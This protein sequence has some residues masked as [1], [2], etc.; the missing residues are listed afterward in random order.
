MR[1]ILIL[2]LIL[3]VCA[4]L[5]AQES[6]GDDLGMDLFADA[7]EETDQSEENGQELD[8]FADPDDDSS[9]DL[10]ADSEDDSGMDLFAEAG[11]GASQDASQEGGEPQIVAV[12]KNPR[13]LRRLVDNINGSTNAR[14]HWFFL[15]MDVEE[16]A[17]PEPDDKRHIFEAHSQF[18]SYTGGKNWRF[19]FEATT[20]F[21]NQDNSYAPALEDVESR[22]WQD[23]FQDTKRER[24]YLSANQFYLSFF[25]SDV[26]FFVGKKTIS[27]TLSTLYSPADIYTPTDANSPFNATFLGRY[28]L[29]LD[30]YFGT[31]SITA[32]VFPV[33][34]G[35]KP[36]YPLSRWGYYKAK[37]KQ[38]EEGITV[39]DQED[40][41]DEERRYTDISWEN[42]SYFLKFKST[43]AGI[44]M[45]VSGFYG[46]VNNTVSEVFINEEDEEEKKSVVVPVV[47]ATGGFS[48][49]IQKLEMHGEALFNYSLDSKDDD[50]LRYVLGGRYI[51]D[52]FN[53]WVPL[54][55]IDVMLEY[56][57]EW[58]IH[59]QSHEDF[60][61]STEE[62][63]GIKNDVLA[64]LKFQ[65]NDDLLFG[66]F[67]QY[68]LS[69]R[70]GTF[71]GNLNY[72]G[73]ENFDLELTGQYFLAPEDTDYYYWR[74]NHRLFATVSYSF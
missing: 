69:Q 71:L 35:G 6:T 66:A 37:E 8:L 15:P 61:D 47:N 5:A 68:D 20:D 45:F 34:Q 59:Q 18:E 28:L 46:L 27:N 62:R 73:I 31:S 16:D 72:R 55:R 40:S 24:L 11:E 64:S 26:D 19:A 30:Y 54:D 13:V 38:D 21:G 12:E 70:G 51:L 25:L 65:V 49:T 42:I 50:Y 44:D 74:H 32:A 43:F 1:L 57:G 36:A 56:G 17:S 52:G 23:W 63:R 9:M 67:A 48:T 10:F 7:V 58:L 3:S 53:E 41:E 2:I 29:E 33:Y 39:E 60:Q 22:D 14:Y 4:S